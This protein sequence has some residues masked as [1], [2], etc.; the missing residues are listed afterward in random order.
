[1]PDTLPAALAR[2]NIKLKPEQV[3]DLQQYCEMLADWNEKL[4]L[5]R[6]TDVETFVARDVVDT[7]ELSRLLGHEE[8]VLDVG[9][10]GG[11]P[12][13]ILAIIRPD[14]QVTLCESVAKKAAVL[15]QMVEKLALPIPV[16]ANRAE[17]LLE[18]FRF[19]ALVLRAVGPLW[20]I[21]HWFEPH[22]PGI[23]RVLAIKGPKWVDERAEARHRGLMHPCELRKVHSYPMPGTESESVILKMWAKGAPEPGIDAAAETPR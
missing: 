1:M 9:S 18:E 8:E 3:A 7:V 21:C 22:W 10:G 20:K 2:H 13:I 15:D 12:G 5:T 14:L 23:G 19:D 16:Y 4:N 17:D 6:H 11:V